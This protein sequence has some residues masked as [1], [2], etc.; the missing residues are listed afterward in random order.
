MDPRHIY[1]AAL[2]VTTPFIAKVWSTPTDADELCITAVTIAPTKTPR[3][4]LLPSKAKACANIGASVYG[5]IAPDIQSSP[6][7]K[8]PNDIN[9]SPIFFFFSFFANITSIAPIPIISGA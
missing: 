2:V 4:G 9:I 6:T 7:N 8:R 3:K 1:T 5:F